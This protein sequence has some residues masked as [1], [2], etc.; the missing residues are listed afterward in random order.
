MCRTTIL[1]IAFFFFQVN[2]SQDFGIEMWRDHLPYGN[3][4]HVV[5]DGSTCYGATPFGLI[6]Y[7]E[8]DKSL[9]RLTKINGLNDF[10]VSCMG[11]NSK[12]KMV[13]VGYNNGNVDLIKENIVFNLNAIF[14]SNLLGNKRINAIHSEGDLTYLA[15]GFGIVVLDTKKREVKDTY[16]FG[17]NG[18]PMAIEDVTTSLSEIIC[19][20]PNGLFRANKSNNFLADFNQWTKVNTIENPMAEYG[21]ILYHNNQIWVVQKNFEYAADSLFV[22]DLNFNRL[23]QFYGDDFYGLELKNDDIIVCG[24]LNVRLLSADFVELESIYTY[25][26]NALVQPNHCIWDGQFYWIGDRYHSLNYSI[27]NWGTVHLGLAGPANNNCFH[28]SSS[29]NRLWV[30]AGNVDGSAWNNT[31]NSNGFSTFDQSDWKKY[32]KLIYNQLGGDSVFD[33]TSICINPLNENHIFACSFFAGVFEFKDGLFKNHYSHFNSSLQVS[34]MHG[35]SQVKVASA[36]FDKSGNVWLANSFCNNPLT[37]ITPEGESMSFSCGSAANNAVLNKVMYISQTGQLWLSVRGKGIVVYDFNNTPLDASDDRYILLNN[38]EANGNL[39]SV[40]VNDIVLDKDNEVWI[41]TEKG[42][43]VFYSITRI[44]DD[45]AT[46]QRVLLEQD[47]GYYYLLED[48]NVSAI[49]IDGADRKWFGTSSG[50]LFLMSA[51]GTKQLYSFTT[52]NS[53]IYSNSIL[54]LAMNDQSGELFIGTDRGIIGFKGTS[55]EA[56]QAFNDV[57][58]FPNPVRPE[59]KGP[60]AIRGLMNKSDVKITDARGQLVYATISNGGQAVWNGN[61]LTGSPVASG[62]YYVFVV[63]GDGSQKSSTKILIIR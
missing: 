53:P 50:G 4:T 43:A 14:V 25:A 15:C 46:A 11:Y 5:K 8:E 49:V 41:G 32:D 18:T 56:K 27:S 7:D 13:I 38:N 21:A 20:T 60:I 31:Y 42:P 51:D 33:F 29:R 34:L 2:Y 62:V 54:S 16:I 10:D 58:A 3:V 48:Q 12:N 1:I 61:D 55:T 36:T 22:Y 57:Y 44:F 52:E 63:S 9:E 19:S 45:G 40:N 35:N 6:K 17:P 28:L 23:T 59:H 26:N 24:N 47:G 30:A 37:V 39:P